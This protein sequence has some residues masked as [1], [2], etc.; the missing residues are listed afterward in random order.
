[1]THAS[2]VPLHEPD[3]A[4]VSL[5]DRASLTVGRDST[6]DVVLI[7]SATAERQFTLERV[8]GRWLV[9]HAATGVS[10][11]GIPVVGATR[12]FDRDII[13]SAPSYRWEFISGEQRTVE[14][15][16]LPLLDGPSSNRRKREFASS[17]RPLPVTSIALAILAVV[18]V[19]AGVVILR[20]GPQR[21][22]SALAVLSDAQASRFDSL[23]VVAY[24]HL[25]RG[26]SLLELGIRDEAAR[27]FAR[28]INTLALSDLRNHPQVKPR[29]AALEASIASIYR[30]R[31]LTV[32]EAYAGAS[33]AISADK[34][35]NAS[36]SRE[37][38]AHAFELVSSAYRLR[39]RQTIVVVGRDHPEHLALY[40][41][42]GALDLRSMF[43][44]PEQ[45]A[46]VIAQ[47][48]SFGIR[49]KDFSQDSI[50]RLQVAAAIRAGVAER[51][52]TG[53]HLHIDRFADRRDRW[54]IGAKP[55]APRR[56]Q[57]SRNLSLATP[58]TESSS[59]S[60]R[61]TGSPRSSSASLTYVP[62]SEESMRK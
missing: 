20:Y 4:P 12:L 29:I 2:L 15:P 10:V 24:D 6:C 28:G 1:M 59:P 52:G 19:V 31:Q 50:L 47:C 58:A 39:F 18:L 42:G 30:A 13:A 60:S 44:T 41:A 34:M 40:G 23:L 54:T 26:N 5:L 25:E 48:R 3:A 45:I 49:V 7:E 16:R 38:F 55:D 14:M 36:L 22:E 46:Y 62:L 32:P 8:D 9:T 11:N 53:L 43:M 37:Q 57:T 61:R 21:A 27:E 17:R 56:T 35:R 33:A 51:A